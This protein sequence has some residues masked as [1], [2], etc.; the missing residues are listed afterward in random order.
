MMELK[1]S[2]WAM[3]ASICL[4]A[5]VV[6]IVDKS[7]LLSR[8]NHFFDPSSHPTALGLEL[9]WNVSEPQWV[10]CSWWRKTAHPLA[11][12]STRAKTNGCIIVGCSGG[13]NQ[14]RRD[15]CKG[16]EIVRLLNATLLLPRFEASPY[17]NDT[18]GFADIFDVDFFLES[19]DG[20]VEVLRE[21]PVGLGFLEPVVITCHKA[22]GAFD[23]VESLLPLLLQHQVILLRPAASQRADR[24]FDSAKGARCHVCYQ[25]LRVVRHLQEIAQ[26]IVQRLP[27]PFIALHL[28]FEPDMIAYSRC[29]YPNLSTTSTAAI[30][31]VRGARGARQALGESDANLWRRK[32][33][34]PLTP[35]E[36][37]FLL[38]A[39]H[40]PVTTT[41]YL[42]AGS[43][44]L[45][46]PMLTSVYTR[47]VQKA[48]LFS[49]VDHL[50]ALKESSRAAIDWLVA[51]D[52][53]V[54]IATF[55]GNM[56]KMVVTDRTARGTKRN[57]V[58][59]RLAFA[60]ATWQGM[61]DAELSNLMFHRHRQHVITGYNLPV[62][63]CFCKAYPTLGSGSAKNN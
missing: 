49:H 2:I 27:R 56:D 12:S 40:I 51:L 19:V 4:M 58:L 61:Q 54:Y 35:Q 17:W 16:V 1:P 60:D 38:Q 10:P 15:F 36:T 7:R 14:M 52:A 31:R 6:W 32:G 18:S 30:E 22:T 63:D 26:A 62:S 48:E 21:L 50:E 11:M 41:I 43:E 57:L 39:L 53:D 3:V 23:Y 42:A 20:W 5:T 44:L 46:A 34:C 24:N 59:D 25:S 37:A 9:W 29:H 45:D 8:H 13:L 55:V 33:K 28:R 47:V